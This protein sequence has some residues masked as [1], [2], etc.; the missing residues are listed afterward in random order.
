M[1]T[2][3]PTTS[4]AIT[5]PDFATVLVRITT[6]GELSVAGGAEL[7]PGLVDHS[8]SQSPF[9]VIVTVPLSAY[10]LKLAGAG[11]PL[12]LLSFAHWAPQN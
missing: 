11:P 9:V 3:A 4:P 5:G 2:T 1:T 7:F 12:R 6:K 8:P 10:P